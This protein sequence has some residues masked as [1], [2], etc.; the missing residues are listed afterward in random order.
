MEIKLQAKKQSLQIL[1]LFLLT[2]LIACQPTIKSTIEPAE[3]QTLDKNIKVSSGTGVSTYGVFITEVINIALEELGYQTQPIKQLDVPIVHVAVSNGDL[4]FYSNHWE[5]LHNK[6]FIENGGEEQFQRV[7]TVI[8]DTLQGYQIDKKTADKYKISSLDQL[9]NPQIAQL[10][11]SDGDGK[12]N[13]TGCNPGWGCELVIE[14]H[15]DVYGLRDTVAHDQGNYDTLMADVIARQQQGEAVLYYVYTPS[16]VPIALEQDQEVIWLEV[17]FTSLPQ[18]QGAVS[19]QDTV[20]DGKNLG[21]AVDR[22]RVLANK[23]FLTANPTAKRLFEMIAIPLEDINAQQKLVQ[24]GENSS[25]DI[26]RHAED[27]VKKNQEK[28]SGWLEEARKE[29][30]NFSEN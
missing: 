14:H 19:E 6:F 12:A 3:K 18:E 22:V 16:W 11:D 25:K 27:W 15:L 28:F 23:N 20:A 8:A 30:P 5:K 13:L 7:G 9:K 29:D 17:P 2:F 10:F 4:D 1:L 21:I 26:R 24:D